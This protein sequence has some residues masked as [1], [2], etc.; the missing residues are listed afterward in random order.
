MSAA[1]AMLFR[2]RGKRQLHITD[3]L[4]YLYLTLGTLIMLGPV[5]WGVTSS[6]KTPAAITRF[7]PEFF[8]FAE[9]TVVVEG[10]EDPLPLF[11]VTMEDGT[12]RRL[13]QVR[14]VGLERQMIDPAAPEAGIIKA[15]MDATEIVQEFR[16]AWENYAEPLQ[17]FDFVVYFR[18]SIVV[19]ASAT[20]LT[21]L[22]NSMLAF[23]LSKYR[24]RGQSA[25]LNIFLIMILLPGAVTLAPK[26]LVI[27]SLGWNNNLLGVIIPTLASP[28]AV[29]LLR[30]Y[31]LTLPDELVDAARVDG[32]SEWY[33]Y[34]RIILP[35]SMPALATLAIFSI[36]WRWNDFLWPLIVLTENRNF[37]LQV[38]LNLF[39]GQYD[40][41]WGYLL[42][43]TVLSLLPVTFIF[44]FL[45]KYIATGIATTGLK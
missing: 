20:L 28:T 45:Q 10:Y 19:T 7:P 3:M 9:K 26:Y 37:T 34:W 30:Q 29:F 42:A 27:T 21:L 14:R 18:N 22:L 5:L 11:D 8:P 25:I 41:Q 43:M 1:T 17:Q 23:A 33:I 32:A 39:Q 36:M 35:L 6:F 2:T 31:M 12:V 40:V 24:F 4:S 13:A 15:K 38:A 44:A 16:L